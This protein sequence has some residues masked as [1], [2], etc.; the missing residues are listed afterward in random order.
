MSEWIESR[1]QRLED[2]QAINQLF[3]DYGD[4]LDSGDFD[5]YAD[6]FAED[7]E[8]L[9]GPLGKATGRIDIKALMTAMLADKVGST[10]HI[11]S[12]PRIALDG[13]QA[14]ATVMWSVATLDDDGLA[15]TSRWSATTSILSSRSP[16]GGTSNAARG[17]S[18]C[19]RR[20]PADRVELPPSASMWVVQCREGAGTMTRTVRA[21]A[22]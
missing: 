8:V 16:G 20:C 1:V 22:H 5:A 12:S 7:G 4:Y 3:I 6:L 13:D 9:F 14:T 15:R 18:T 21:S 19:R 10:Y 2:V 11:I 17:R